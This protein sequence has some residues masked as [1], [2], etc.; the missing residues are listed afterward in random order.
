MLLG[1]GGLTSPKKLHG[2]GATVLLPCQG[3]HSKLHSHLHNHNSASDTATPG[4]LTHHLA[5][6]TAMLGVSAPPQA[7]ATGTAWRTL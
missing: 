7:W 2:V 1:R 6:D 3:P 4:Q 5:S